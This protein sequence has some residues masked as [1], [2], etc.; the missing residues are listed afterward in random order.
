[1]TIPAIIA[2]VAVRL[3][4]FCTPTIVVRPIVRLS[5]DYGNRGL[6]AAKRD[7]WVEFVDPTIP[8]DEPGHPIQHKFELRMP[9]SQCM[10]CHVHPGTNVLN[11]Y[12]GF[13]WW[14]NETDGEF[15]YPKEQKELTAEEYIAA[16]MSN[17]NEAAARG[18]WS[19]P[20]FLANVS[21]LNDRL[22]HTQFADFHGHGWVYRAVFKKNRRGKLLDWC[23]R[24]LDSVPNEHLQA[25]LS[26]ASHQEQQDGK[27]RDHL[28]VHL[29][30]IHLEK[31][32]HCVDC[33]FYQD[34]H[35]DTKLYGEVRAAIEIQCIDCHGTATQN[36]AEL[37]ESQIENGQ[38]PR[39][40]TSGP[41]APPEG[42]NL[43]ALRTA[44]G[45]PRFEVVY[46]PGA[47]PKLIQRS[48]V[49]PDLYWEITQTAD[50]VRPD[51]DDYNPRS[52]AAKSARLGAD[53]KVVW[54][55]TSAEDFAVCPHND[56]NMSCIACHS[57]WNPSCF[58]CHLAS[59]SQHQVP[60]LTQFG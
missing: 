35:G 8:K 27:Q 26:P 3:V 11:S 4:T 34:G 16:T 44:F 39:L 25:A 5:L 28:P 22:Q 36:L 37:L 30:D 19:D 14:D 47:P 24:A 15:M 38:S 31:G 40:P 12:A 18:L 41:A 33:H 32:M 51:A 53:G 17:P 46:A 55:G 7:E 13:M 58:G 59:K 50:T 57:S 43:L 54:G 29:A 56:D 45:K 52:H 48:N 6:A 49:E 20:E 2:A 60:G 10:V 1:M 23:G 21:D 42:T 9:T